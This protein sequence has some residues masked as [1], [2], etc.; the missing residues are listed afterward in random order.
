MANVLHRVTKSYV[1][2]VNTP[3]FSVGEWIHNPD[4]SAVVGFSS[5]YWVVTGD[6]VTLMDQAARDAVDA[7][8]VESRRDQVV[9][10]L[11]Q[12]EDVLRAF[13]LVVMD[14]INLLRGQH[15]LADRTVAQLR[16]AIRGKL[17][18]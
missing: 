3:E 9:A 4:L 10:Q 6:V 5:K 13:M 12:V 16:S 17:G 11:D 8:E 15:A 1:V 2:S 7:A 18:S 14:E